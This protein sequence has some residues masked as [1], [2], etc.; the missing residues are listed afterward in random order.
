MLKLTL[1][2]RVLTEEYLKWGD[3]IIADIEKPSIE[4]QMKCNTSEKKWNSYVLIY[5]HDF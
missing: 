2:G 4:I 3:A 5:C 1:S